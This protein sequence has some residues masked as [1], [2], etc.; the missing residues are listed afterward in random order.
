M[1]TTFLAATKASFEL[2]LIILISSRMDF[3][4]KISSNEMNVI[5]S[6]LAIW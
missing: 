4:L 5:K 6:P 1:V 2:A 3:E